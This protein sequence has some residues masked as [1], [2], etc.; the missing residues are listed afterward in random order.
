MVCLKCV[1]LSTFVLLLIL[2]SLFFISLSLSPPP[3]PPPSN[4]GVLNM[5]ST[6]CEGEGRGKEEERGG[7]VYV[8]KIDTYICVPL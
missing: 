4:N 7:C 3:P 8:R 6:Q 2:W 5:S 1:E